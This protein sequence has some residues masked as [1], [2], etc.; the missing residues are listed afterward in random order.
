MPVSLAIIINTALLFAVLAFRVRLRERSLSTIKLA[1]WLR[2]E[3]YKSTD[4]GSDI[5]WA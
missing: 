2:E 4:V 3:S 1:E 5:T